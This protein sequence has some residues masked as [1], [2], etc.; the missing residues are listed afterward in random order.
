MKCIRTLK[1]IKIR[2]TDCYVLFIFCLLFPHFEPGCFNDMGGMIDLLYNICK[3]ISTFIVLTLYLKKGEISHLF[4]SFA[5]LWIYFFLNTIA[6]NGFLIGEMVRVL[7]YLVVAMMVEYYVKK[8]AKILVC[9]LVFL[10]EFLVI[11]NFI[12]ILLFPTGMYETELQWENYFLGFRNTFALYFIPCMTFEIIWAK[13]VG[14]W[15]RAIIMF[16]VCLVSA[17]FSASAT[18]LLITVAYIVLFAT[19]IYCYKIFNVIS[20]MFFYLAAFFA[21]VILRLQSLLEPLFNALGRNITMTGRTLIWDYTI[22]KIMQSPLTGY[23]KQSAE[24]RI[25]QIPN[26]YGASHAHNL[27]L[28]HLYCGGV[29]QLILLIVW[30]SFLCKN[31]WKA[32][33]LEYTH[34]I[35]I[36]ITAFLFMMLVEICWDSGVYG[37]FMLAGYAQQIAMQM[38]VAQ[39]RQRVIIRTRKITV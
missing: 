19:R 12:T 16:T 32:R 29:I 20:G 17:V 33:C 27:I 25:A 4:I 21:V 5:M 3:V 7:S 31:L 28:E 26:V 1:I 36:G 2:Q 38:P 34:I 39:K 8:Q 11:V 22:Q 14:K 37:F 9:A 30:F 23:G 18:C 35:M 15:R 13:F 24:Y 6:K 10:Y